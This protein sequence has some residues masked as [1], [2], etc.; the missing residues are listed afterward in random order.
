MMKARSLIQQSFVS[1][2]VAAVA[3]LSAYPISAHAQL[4]VIISGGFSTAYRQV[5]PEFERS[6]GIT[7]TTLSGSS[8]GKG[9]ETIAAQLGR[10]VPADVA[11]LSR[12]GLTE[13][14]AAG[15]IL[16]ATDV[17]LARAA[18]GVSVRSGTPK[19]DISTVEAFRQALV[20]AR[21]VAA[22]A[23]TSGIY[24]TTELFPRLGIADKIDTKIMPRGSQSAALVASGDAGIV[25]QPISELL[26]VPGL[27]FVGRIPA[28]LQLVQ[29]FAAAIVAGST[30]VEASRQL[31][32]FLA[33]DR[34]ATAIKNNGMEPVEKR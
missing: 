18:L 11:I 13:L 17:D 12:E 5:L 2:L 16:A 19:P 25:V 26:Q 10:G 9:P 23:S 22:P 21:V 1:V 29:T 3:T 6:T 20:G 8:Q 14:I 30:D 15:R 33:S 4:K 31:I 27:D 28:E 24:L 34:A 7:V 32:A